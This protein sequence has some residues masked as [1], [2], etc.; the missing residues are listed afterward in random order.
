MHVHSDEMA[1]G[2]YSYGIHILKMTIMQIAY[3]KT[4]NCILFFH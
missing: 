4:V 2:L 1:A 3:I